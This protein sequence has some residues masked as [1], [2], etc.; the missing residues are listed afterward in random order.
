MPASQ[1]RP[2]SVSIAKPPYAAS[3]CSQT[4]WSEQTA[5]ISAIGSI[6]PVLVVPAVA[7][8]M[9]GCRPPW[10]SASI[11]AAS[12]SGRM[13]RC[14]STP[15]ERTCSGFTPSTWNARVTDECTCDVT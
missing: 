5:A 2:R 9:N 3:T 13:R 11:A 8:T 14:S 10:T 12:A 1:P 6:A 7:T 15:I 4:S